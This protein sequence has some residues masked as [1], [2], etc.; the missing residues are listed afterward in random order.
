MVKSIKYSVSIMVFA[1]LVSCS[2]CGEEKKNRV[3]QDQINPD[4]ST[5][6]EYLFRDKIKHEQ[7]K[8]E[9]RSRPFK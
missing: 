9:E 1:I 2:G 3:H 8:E 6:Y 4:G 7:E 5:N